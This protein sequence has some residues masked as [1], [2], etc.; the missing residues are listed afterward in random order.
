MHKQV[1]I[2]GGGPAGTATALQL[3]A[4]GVESIIIE[5]APQPIPKPGETLPPQA[6]QV[7]Q[8]LQL[9]SLLEHPAHIACYGN[10]AVWGHVRPIDKI[11]FH[12][13][14]PQGWHI[15]RQTF[16][17]QLCQVAHARGVTIW[18]GSTVQAVT[19]CENGWQVQCTNTEKQ[20]QVA[21]C[22][23]IVDATGRK[24][25]IARLLNVPRRNLD[26]LVGSYAIVQNTGS[27]QQYT[28]IEAVEHG[29]WYG[30]P[31]SEEQLV[32]TYMTDADVI[33]PF[34]RTS[35]GFQQLYAQTQFLPT[36][37][38]KSIQPITP[39]LYHAATGYLQQR[40]G[41][42]WLAVGDAAFAYDPI[43]SHGII[44]AME[45]GY[46][47]GHAIAAHLQGNHDAL[48]AYDYAISQGF[49]TYMQMHADYYAVEQRWKQSPFWS[50]R[51]LHNR[52]IS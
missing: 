29:W 20:R 32:L 1:I 21:A 25:R 42:N 30:A 15:H 48:I 26:K 41:N 17:S 12:H 14:A 19:P 24:S 6:R 22:S 44:S 40:H 43:S 33:S 18:Q 7:F 34:N 27:L 46:Y 37:L 36:V 47:A 52:A 23:F 16:E 3:A 50:R 45:S 13:T 51:G 39:S 2:V 11:F 4:L 10:R 9:Q 8:K 49:S 38:T 31:L 28:Y 35:G 5:A